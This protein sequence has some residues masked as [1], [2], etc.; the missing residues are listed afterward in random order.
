[1]KFKNKIILITGGTGSFGK[2]FVKFALK[3][4]DFK[5]I[6]IFSRDEMKQYD[7]RNSFSKKDNTK[8]R[9]LIGDIRDKERLMFAME[10]VDI[11]I[12]AAALKQVDTAEYNP[13]EAVKTNIMGSQNV[14]EASLSNNVDK[15]IA[16]STDKA[17]SPVNLYG[18]SKLTADKLFVSANNY[19]GRKKTLFSVVRYGN[20]FGSRGS[21]LPLFLNQKKQNIFTVTDNRMT[22]FSITLSSAVNFVFSSL[23]NMQG[24]E[25]FIPKLYSYN[26]IDVVK[27]ISLKP[28]INIIGLRPGEKLH[29]EM[30]SSSASNQILE[31]NNYYV[32]LPDSNYLDYNEK[33][34]YFKNLKNKKFKKI[35]E[36]FNYNSLENKN[37]LKVKD[38]KKLIKDFIRFS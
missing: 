7:M 26:I 11:V 34:R 22:R 20:V 25:I 33:N 9:F 19:K 17:S 31:F 15:V 28:K 32:V 29:E 6:I 8:L 3:N 38:I 4:Y 5:K 30:I 24:A 37:Y 12:H 14:I 23:M 21:V 13:F 35:K 36:N 18:A 27:A 16:L 1:M 10:N 2:E